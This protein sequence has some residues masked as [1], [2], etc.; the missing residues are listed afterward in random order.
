MFTRDDALLVVSEALCDET[1]AKLHPSEVRAIV[2]RLYP[3]VSWYEAKSVLQ[4][5][6]VFVDNATDGTYVNIGRPNPVDLANALSRK[7]QTFE[8]AA[9][10]KVAKA[11]LAE[12]QARID[13]RKVELLERIA[14]RL[15]LLQLDADGRLQVV[16]QGGFTQVTPD[17]GSAE[18]LDGEKDPF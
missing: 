9:A 5:F 3:Q 2:N 7:R 8:R 15:E 12:G 4:G 6:M 18:Y 13:A 14:S 17:T 16:L 11:K 10:L 1:E